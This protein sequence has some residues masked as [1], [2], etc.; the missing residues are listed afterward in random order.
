MANNPTKSSIKK[1][2]TKLRNSS[3]EM[4]A[5]E[6]RKVGYQV[7]DSI[8]SFLSTV[9]DGP[10][11]FGESANSIRKTL[12]N[13]KIPQNGSAPEH[14]F[15]EATD[16]LFKHSLFNG[17]PRF[18]GYVTSSAA[19]IGALGDLLASA[20]NPN[21]GAAALS[22]MATEIETQTIRWIASLIG[23]PEDCGGLLVSGG[24]IA[25]FIGFLAA[26]TSKVNWNIRNEG[27]RA[28]NK[29]LLVYTS[30]S[31]HTW[32]EKAADIF[33]LGTN[34]IRW[35]KVDNEQQM[36]MED[37]QNQ[38]LKDQSE[39]LLPFM[40]VGAAGTVG[41][42]AIDPLLEISSICKKYNLWFHVDGAYGAPAAALPE[43][44]PQLKGLNLA[45]SIAL[46]PHKWLY[47]PLEAGC[48]LVKD[49]L[50][51]LNTFSFH[52]EYYSFVGNEENPSHNYYEFGLQNSR[53]FR[54]LKVWLGIRQAGREGYIEM[55]RDDIKLSKTL[56]HLIEKQDE[57]EAISQSLSIATFRYK[58][59]HLPKNNVAL[60]LNELNKEL[61]DKLQNN[62]EVY[63]SNAIVNDKYV[64]RACIVNFRTTL[65][66]IKALPEIVVRMGRELSKRGV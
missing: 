15:Q 12:G 42:G 25:N 13:E 23:Y 33:G 38:I 65:N 8:S 56:F 47:S 11:T 21:V 60:Y 48:I 30:K 43:A 61:L 54:A 32:I 41:T 22:P 46:D 17:H 2:N 16:L 19:P 20:V 18:W 4:S 26:R 49:P 9:K 44:S 5:E 53:G 3:L 14:L 34:S 62:G 24:N 51:L 10:V 52:P 36:D 45:D 50:T 63:I 39:D 28:S 40:V 27:I 29:Q 66:D 7:I 57:L 1:E 37:L 31:T 35:I 59:Q 58:P 55:I 6:F 64:L